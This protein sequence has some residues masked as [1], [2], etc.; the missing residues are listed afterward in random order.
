MIKRRKESVMKEK[1]N[2]SGERRKK[3][4]KVLAAV[5]MP[6]LAL[7]MAA[8]IFSGGPG[9]VQAANVKKVDSVTMN[10][11]SSWLGNNESTRYNGRVWSDKSVSTENVTFGN[12]EVVEIGDSDFLTTYSLLG[13]SMKVSRQQPTDTVFILD[14]STSM[15][16]GYNKD[17]ESVEQEDSRIQALVNSVNKAIDTLAKANPENR[18]AIAVFNGSST[19]LLPE[20]TTGSKILEKVQ[21]GKYLE[22]TNYNF[23]PGKDG[24]KAF[25]TCHINGKEANTDGGTNIQAGMFAG[26]KILADEK[27]TTYELADGTQV[28]RIP[29]VVFMSDGAPTT[30][31]SAKNAKYID[32]NNG[33][34]SGSITNSTN[35]D[36]E[37]T[38]QSGSWWES[39]SGE[40]IGS[41]DNDNP[42]SADG[43]MALLTA[44]YLKNEISQNYYTGTDQANI[45]TIGFAT[46]VQTDAMVEMANLVLDPGTYIEKIT[47]VQAVEDVKTAW[48]TYSGNEETIV[49]A[50]IGKGNNSTKVE[51]QVSHPT[52]DAEKNNPTSLIY[53]TQVFNAEDAEELN[54][55]FQEIANRI[56]SEAQV[57][58]EIT[59]NDPVQ[60]G[61]ITYEDPIG[62]Y[63]QVDDVPAVMYFDER[64]DKKDVQETTSNGVTTKTYIFAKSDGSTEIESPVYGTGDINAIQITVVEDQDGKQTL[65][66][67]VPASA[68][69]LRVNTVTL[70]GDG[71][72]DKNEDNGALPLRV[73]YRVSLKDEVTDENG[74]INAAALSESYINNNLSEVTE[75]GQSVKKVNFYA[76]RYNRKTEGSDSRTMGEAFIKFKPASTNPF[77]FVQENTP[78]YLNGTEGCLLYTSDAADE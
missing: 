42:D 23:E 78:L 48:K 13:T 75:G 29:N 52:G 10:D 9:Q 61:Y 3:G 40:A 28:T 76:N 25:V 35:L 39:S 4:R 16:W 24:G 14:F 49:R 15:T 7:A 64:F 53:P 71:T 69:P 34:R 74:N 51:Y 38:V 70:K 36:P 6:V 19:A 21:D 2:I 72:V 5:L 44:S 63:M 56:T 30:F 27:D 31:A 22:I 26:M 62:E 66:V 55:I 54:N 65:K 8:G 11:Y 32:E 12:N 17:H 1:K 50:P 43:F 18:I 58:T 67:Q 60:D 57:P 37:R 73:L 77:Y 46:D 20:L 59:G 45:Y 41:G 68:I 33:E 47:A